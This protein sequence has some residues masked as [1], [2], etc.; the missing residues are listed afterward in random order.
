M[1]TFSL[2]LNI[3]IRHTRRDDLRKLEWFGSMTEFRES[4]EHDY[5]RAEGGEVACLVAEANDFP[6]GQVLVDFVKLADESVGVIWA[7]RVLFNMHNLGIGTRLTEA[8]EHCIREQGLHT[9]ELGVAKDNPNAKRLYER[10]GYHVIRD[11]IDCWHY[12]TPDGETKH[13]EEHIWI[14]RKKLIEGN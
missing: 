8:A 12:T 11:H 10:L 9:A 3:T 2:H 14:L 5:Q 7:L 13:I 1:A 6:I 4:I